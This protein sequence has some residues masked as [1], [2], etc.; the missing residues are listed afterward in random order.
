MIHYI[1]PLLWSTIMIYYHDPLLECP[2]AHAPNLIMIHYWFEV[3][4]TAASEL[5]RLEIDLEAGQFSDQL[6]SYILC[7]FSYLYKIVQKSVLYN[8]TKDEMWTR[9]NIVWSLLDMNN[10]DFQQYLEPGCPRRQKWEKFSHSETSA[11]FLS[12][13]LS[14]S[15]PLF[16]L[17]S[18][19]SPAGTSNILT[20]WNTWADLSLW[21]TIFALS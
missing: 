11:I 12:P 13:P 20:R 9:R 4:K 15:P 8:S 18:P 2:I 5:I 17:S 19:L 10:E 21:W 16:P 14:S 6:F 3:L 7:S 1:D